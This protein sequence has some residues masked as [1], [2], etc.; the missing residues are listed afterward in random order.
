MASCLSSTQ[1]GQPFLV[2]VVDALNVIF[3][4]NWRT[5]GLNE[6]GNGGSEAVNAL[7]GDRMRLFASMGG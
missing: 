4:L 5:K 1:N 3:A 2:S 6:I 7:F